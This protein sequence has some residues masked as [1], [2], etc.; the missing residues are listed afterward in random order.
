VVDPAF[1]LFIKDEQNK[2]ER[3]GKLKL[4]VFHLLALHQI[5]EGDYYGLQREV[6]NSL[7]DDGLV[8]QAGDEFHLCEAYSQAVKR[9]RRY[10]RNDKRNDN[11]TINSLS[12]EILEHAKNEDFAW[13]D[14]LAEN[15]NSSTIGTIN[16]TI[17]GKMLVVLS[18]IECYPGYKRSDLSEV[19]NI[20][21]GSISKIL[22]SLSSESYKLVE[23]IGPNKTGG[24]YL[25]DFGQQVLTDVA[26][27][28][29]QH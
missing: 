29:Y 4:S 13:I 9:A 23:F 15:A 6:L 24:Y 8:L 10:K 17:N 14:S 20:P 7:I 3:E 26:N 5:A 22:M 16:G 27:T 2:R 18:C 11:G 12:K 25:T 28:L 19:L 1:H 21:L